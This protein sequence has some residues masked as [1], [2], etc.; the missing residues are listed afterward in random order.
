[1]LTV[2]ALRAAKRLG[3]RPP[4]DFAFVTF[5]Q[6]AYAGLL[7]PSLTSVAQPAVRI[8]QQAMRLMLRRLQTPDAPIRIVRLRPTILHGESCGCGEPQ[9]PL[10]I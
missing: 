1:V 3:L 2:G 7:S 6:L 9:R 4:D 5:D 10:P 8:G